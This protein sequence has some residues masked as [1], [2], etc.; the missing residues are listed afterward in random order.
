MA[1]LT[2]PV[3]RRTAGDPL[4][5]LFARQADGWTGHALAFPSIAQLERSG[6]VVGPWQTDPHGPFAYATRPG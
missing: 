2:A 3:V 4:L 1:I 6:W 5:Y